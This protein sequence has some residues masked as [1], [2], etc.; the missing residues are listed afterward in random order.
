M[1][2]LLNDHWLMR[3]RPAGSLLARAATCALLAALS[4]PAHAQDEDANAGAKE[5]DGTIVVTGSRI[6]RGSFDASSPV[7]AI[8]KN[9]ITESGFTNLGDVLLRSPALAVG[10]G[11]SNAQTAGETAGATFANLRGLG[12]FRTLTLID[13]RR[14]VSGSLT[15]SSVDLSM[16]PPQMVERVEIVTGGTSAV[17]GADAVTGVINVILDR[18]YEGIEVDFSAC[19][20]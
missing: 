15:A 12:S 14:R 3:Q 13:G 20:P 8:D 11:L 17:Y 10:Q 6:K 2:Y 5:A 4:M 1:T 16:F 18:D 19:K 7:T 9:V